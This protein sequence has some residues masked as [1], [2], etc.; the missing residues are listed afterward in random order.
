MMFNLQEISTAQPPDTCLATCG[1]ETHKAKSAIAL[2]ASIFAPM[3]THVTGLRHTTCPE[4]PCPC[5]PK[6]P[7]PL[8]HSGPNARPCCLSPH[9]GST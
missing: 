8:G 1:L 6:V 5:M 3:H 7:T 2:F 9:G 4:G